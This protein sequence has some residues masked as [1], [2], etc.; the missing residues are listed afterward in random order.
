M[1]THRHSKILNQNIICDSET[2]SISTQDG[3][4]YNQSELQQLKNISDGLKRSIHKFKFV[5][6]GEIVNAESL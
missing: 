5:F 3:V 4:E 2:G 6:R 1:I